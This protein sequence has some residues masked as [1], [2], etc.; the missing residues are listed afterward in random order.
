[1]ANDVSFNHMTNDPYQHCKNIAG[2]EK[3]HAD[4]GKKWGTSTITRWAIYAILPCQ[5]DH[6]CLYVY[7][8]INIM[9]LLFKSP[10]FAVQETSDGKQKFSTCKLFLNTYLIV[11]SK[12]DF[13]CLLSNNVLCSRTT[14]VYTSPEA[15]QDTKDFTMSIFSSMCWRLGMFIIHL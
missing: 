3:K 2:W 5:I 8:S 1:M 14:K 12:V 11:D 9:I 13:Q 10:F 6:F 15:T 4:T 7:L